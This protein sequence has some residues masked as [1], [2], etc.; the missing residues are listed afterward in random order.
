MTHFGPV[1]GR[2]DGRGGGEACLPACSG[3]HPCPGNP[4]S[5]RV[6]PLFPCTKEARVNV[7]DNALKAEIE[8]LRAENAALKAQN[9]PAKRVWTASEIS[10]MDHQA[11]LDHE[12]DV[13]AALREGRV[14]RDDVLPT[15]PGPADAGRDGRS[16]GPA[17]ERGRGRA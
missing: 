13:L 1:E 11:Y 9:D 6:S 17:E 3:E 12:R 8:A 15:A 2:K 7:N 14:R 5:S 16:A 4:K 10:A